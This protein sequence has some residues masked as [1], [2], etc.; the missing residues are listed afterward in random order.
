M[1]NEDNE[2]NDNAQYKEAYDELEE[3][4]K[5]F[6]AINQNRSGMVTGFVLFT[7]SQRYDDDGD[8][9]FAYDYMFSLGINMFMGIGLVEMATLRMKTDI[10]HGYEGQ[11]LRHEDDDE[12]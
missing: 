11:R 8:M 3:A 6:N 1:I 4:V 2:P 10:N 9:C 7:A 5:K 12:D